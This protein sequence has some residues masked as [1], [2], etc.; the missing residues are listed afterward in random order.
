LSHAELLQ[1]CID[2]PMT[3]RRY[4]RSIAEDMQHLSNLIESFLRLAHAFAH[5]DRSQHVPVHVHDIVTDAVA[6]SKAIA[7]EHAVS[8]VTT[9]AEDGDNGDA[10]EVLGDQ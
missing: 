4:A 10:V 1:A 2:D 6:S 7:L 9:L 5:E 3:A 8:I